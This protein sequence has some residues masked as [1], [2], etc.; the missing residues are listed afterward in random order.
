MKGKIAIIGLAWS[1]AVLLSFLWNYYS[2]RNHETQ[3]LLEVSRA[4][5]QQIVLTREWNARHGGVYVFVTESTPPNPH[6]KHI[7]RD[8]R[9]NDNKMLTMLNP[10]YMSR[11]LSEIAAEREGVQFHVT[12]LKPIRPENAPVP[13]EREALQAFERGLKEKGEFYNGGYRY[14]APLL[15]EKSC[16]NCH[17]EQGY[18]VGDIRGGIS[19]TLPDAHRSSLFPLTVG[20]LLIAL[21]GLLFIALFGKRLHRAYRALQEQSII[22]P[23]TRIYNRRYFLRQV[24]KEFR[25]AERELYPVALIMTDVD[26]FK[27]YNDT[28]GHLEGDRCLKQ[29]AEA[30]KNVLKR[31]GDCIA[32]YGGEEFVIMLP[33]TPLQSAV[34]IAEQLR[35]AVEGLQI[36][37]VASHGNEVVTVSVGVA[38]ANR[39]GA[40]YEELIKK[41]D[42]ALYRAKQ[43]GK[44]RVE[45]DDIPEPGTTW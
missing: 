45:A 32:R 38:V 20:H 11:Q 14:M 44:N 4:F 34:K 16:L 13:W 3:S 41:A 26:N 28:Y 10:A 22:D 23:L 35:A 33:N 15:T 7:Q 29:A 30:M 2:T 17:D 5:Y 31:P 8:I 1:L 12:S 42:D 19:L 18:K 27:S 9:V 6:L 21:V 37:H 36:P 43:K 39:R 25:R 40:S 24:K